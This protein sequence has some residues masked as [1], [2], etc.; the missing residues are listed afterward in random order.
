MV[1]TVTGVGVGVEDVARVTSV[2]LDGRR[3]RLRRLFARC[4]TGRTLC[5]HRQQNVRKYVRQ[6]KTKYGFIHYGRPM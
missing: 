5:R 6:V 2:A 1:Q 3:S 4:A